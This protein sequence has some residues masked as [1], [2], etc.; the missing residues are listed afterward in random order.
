MS[1]VRWRDARNEDVQDANHRWEPGRRYSEEAPTR[2]AHLR[3]R[4]SRIAHSVITPHRMNF[5]ALRKP[6]FGAHL[7]LVLVFVLT[8]VA[9]QLHLATHAGE[10]GDG[11]SRIA[12]L[13]S[14]GLHAESAAHSHAHAH[15]QEH[16]HPEQP[17]AQD[18]CLHWH[19]LGLFALATPS[20]DFHY[21]YAEPAPGTTL[22]G[23]AQGY[24]YAPRSRAPPA[25]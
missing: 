18:S 11:H 20:T 14:F 17:E 7:L 6:G 2:W 16:A 15:S 13:H 22:L 5:P 9:A 24:H 25:V 19:V 1:F 4:C 8:T 3:Q 10:A 12:E 23:Q 21:G